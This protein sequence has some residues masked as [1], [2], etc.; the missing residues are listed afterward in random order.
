MNSVFFLQTSNRMRVFCERVRKKREKN[1]RDSMR[2][3]QLFLFKRAETRIYASLPSDQKEE[4]H[5]K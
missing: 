1:V 3:F 2:P 5:E 4:E